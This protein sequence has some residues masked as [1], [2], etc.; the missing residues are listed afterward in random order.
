[1]KRNIEGKSTQ[2]LV[3]PD[4][5]GITDDNYNFRDSQSSQPDRSPSGLQET[6]N[7]VIKNHQAEQLNT[8][9]S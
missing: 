8:E 7:L 1:M 3:N 5:M 4:Q 2:I 6:L 9:T